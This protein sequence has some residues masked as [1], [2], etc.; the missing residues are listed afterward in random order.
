MK[1]FNQRKRALQK[2][3][4]KLRTLLQSFQADCQTSYEEAARLLLQLGPDDL[5]M[6]IDWLESYN[7]HAPLLKWNA[8][9]NHIEQHYRSEGRVLKTTIGEYTK[10]TIY[11]QHESL[12]LPR[13]KAHYLFE[14]LHCARSL[15]QLALGGVQQPLEPLVANL[16][17]L[18]ETIEKFHYL[19]YQLLPLYR[20]HMRLQCD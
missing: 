13:K 9:E 5:Q 14:M 6:H 7:A 16:L 1:A 10:L 2:L 8:A 18:G 17:L 20:D 19:V 3:E 15:D 11:M 4:R 12:E